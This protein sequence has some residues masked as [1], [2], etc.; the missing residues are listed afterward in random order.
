MALLFDTDRYTSK[1]YFFR[2]QKFGWRL[3]G[4]WIGSDDIS[5]I[6]F[7]F[8]LF[9]CSEVFGYGVFQ[10]VYFYTVRS[11]LVELFDAI[12][13]F[14]TQIPTVIRVLFIVYHRKYIKLVLDYLKTSFENGLL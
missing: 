3:M 14:A 13:P 4:F 9:N 2:L 12:T 10:T 6:Q 11:N 5:K 1:E 8:L 7:Y